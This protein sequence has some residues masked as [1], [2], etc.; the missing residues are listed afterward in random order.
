MP[1][2]GRGSKLWGDM[3]YLA[4]FPIMFGVVG[5][6]CGLLW[7]VAAGSEGDGGPE[8]GLFYIFGMSYIALRVIKGLELSVW[9]RNL[10]EPK[11]NPVIFPGVAQAG[12][13]SAYPSPPRTYGVDARFKF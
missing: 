5:V 1:A 9:G 3:H 10:S 13:L 2:W 8:P 6:I 11:Y 7:L 4:P 12:T